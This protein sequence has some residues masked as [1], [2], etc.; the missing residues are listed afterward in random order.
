MHICMYVQQACALQMAAKRMYLKVVF[1][2]HCMYSQAFNMA[3]ILAL[4][5]ENDRLR[6]NSDGLSGNVPVCPC[7]LVYDVASMPTLDVENLS[8]KTVENFSYKARSDG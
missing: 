4:E 5:A 6:A 3:H 7:E 2:A 8:Y 1:P